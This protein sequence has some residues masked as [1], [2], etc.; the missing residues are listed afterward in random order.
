MIGK[1]VAI[2]LTLIALVGCVAGC[3]CFS[4][5][6][7]VWAYGLVGI[8]DVIVSIGLFIYKN[9]EFSN[10]NEWLLVIKDGKLIK[11]GVGIYVFK[12]FNSAVV[13]FPSLMQTIDFCADN[14]TIEM[15]GVK[16]SGFVAW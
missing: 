6:P 16:V 13:K 1:F 12:G 14:V 11:A 9:M 3:I 15:Q 10:P 7:P 8:V 5:Y 4:W 2:I